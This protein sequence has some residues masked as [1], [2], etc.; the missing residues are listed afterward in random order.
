M[1]K[2]CVHESSAEWLKQ[3]R[4]S[5]SVEPEI[6]EELH[7]KILQAFPPSFGLYDALWPVVVSQTSYGSRI[8]ILRRVNRYLRDLCNDSEQSFQILQWIE[9]LTTIDY[10]PICYYGNADKILRV[11]LPFTL[12]L[13]EDI[14]CRWWSMHQSVPYPPHI[15]HKPSYA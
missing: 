5:F 2:T 1:E 8:R 9:R 13:S 14:E 6:V 3:P 4:I 12:E 10:S 15:H 7:L 11:G